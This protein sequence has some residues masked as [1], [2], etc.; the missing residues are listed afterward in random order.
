MYSN[1]HHKLDEQLTKTSIRLASL[2]DLNFKIRKDTFLSIYCDAEFV[3]TWWANIHQA[4]AMQPSRST[5][6]ESSSKDVSTLG[7]MS[8]YTMHG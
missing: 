6:F 2:R 5:V 8:M 7:N 1:N 3:C 4:L